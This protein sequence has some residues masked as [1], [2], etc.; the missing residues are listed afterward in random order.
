MAAMAVAKPWTGAHLGTE[1]VGVLRSL[2]NNVPQDD[3]RD[4]DQT[5]R[6]LLSSLFVA[7]NVLKASVETRFTC[8]VLLHRYDAACPVDQHMDDVQWLVAACLFLACKTE[9]EPRRLQDV[10]NCANMIQWEK[11]VSGRE[12][13]RRRPRSS[14]RAQYVPGRKGNACTHGTKRTP[15]VSI[16][17][18]CLAFPSSCPCYSSATTDIV[19]NFSGDAS[20]PES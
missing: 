19:Q 20:S 4:H 17:Y 2:I 13:S 3:A 15:M 14:D 11:E 18:D 12:V 6:P 16:L 1:Q 5:L 7:C 9:E 10:I 8:C